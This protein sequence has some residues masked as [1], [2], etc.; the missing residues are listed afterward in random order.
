MLSFLSF[1]AAHL[2]FARDKI[3]DYL[4]SLDEDNQ[5]QETK[6]QPQPEQPLN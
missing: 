2:F 5:N 1:L 6:P 3:D 4:D